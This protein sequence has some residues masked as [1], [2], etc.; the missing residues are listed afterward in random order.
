MRIVIIGASGTAVETARRLLEHGQDVV[1][2]ETDQ[3]RIDNL[4]EELECGFLHGDGS[5][6]FIL[7]EAS[8][9]NTDILLCLTD[10][11][12]NNIIG[13]LVGRSMGFTRVIVKIG[14]PDY[15]PVCD[16]LGLNDIFM[17]EHEFGRSLVNLIEADT[18]GG[19]TAELQGNLRFFSL[20]VAAGEEGSISDLS[21]PEDVHAVAVT[22]NGAS[23]PVGDVTVL[24]AGDVVLLITPEKRLGELHETYEAAESDSVNV[25]ER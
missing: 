14:D 18:R 21:L 4:S 16:E 15:Q 17:P 12:Q 22:R 24:R 20:K 23:E 6:P 8:P 9:D 13:A 10:S 19:F 2:I 25:A 11:D 5:R 7:R 1:I 3:E